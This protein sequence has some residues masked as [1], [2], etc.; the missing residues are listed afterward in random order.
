MEGARRG[1]HSGISR[2][3]PV[4]CVTP[5][6]NKALERR[7]GAKHRTPFFGVFCATSA[8]FLGLR[9][10]SVRAFKANL[11]H[12][13]KLATR[14]TCWINKCTRISKT[15]SA[16]SVGP[17]CRGLLLCL[18]TSSCG[19]SEEQTGEEQTGAPCPLA[20]CCPQISCFVS[21]QQA[22]QS[23]H[24][25]ARLEL[26]SPAPM[27]ALPLPCPGSPCQQSS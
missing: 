24:L 15:C 11:A 12:A 1:I 22:Q 2:T 25:A 13:H 27:L 20:S 16:S 10:N 21:Q 7:R 3:C 6:T 19:W 18:V 9:G 5:C 26:L 14:Q 8:P 23:H 17:T 4:Q